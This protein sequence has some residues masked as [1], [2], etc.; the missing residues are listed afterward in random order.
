MGDVFLEQIVK[1]EPT[2]QEKIKKALILFV[3]ILFS[4]LVFFISFKT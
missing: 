1:K 3:F 2:V 4:I